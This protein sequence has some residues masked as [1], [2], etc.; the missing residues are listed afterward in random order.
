MQMKDMKNKF[1]IREKTLYSILWGCTVV[2]AGAVIVLTIFAVSRRSDK[3][4]A[5]PVSSVVTTANAGTSAPSTSNRV[6]S[7]TAPDT[8]EEINAPVLRFVLP[9]AGSLAKP[10]CIDTLSYSITMND[11]RTHRGVDLSA[12]IGDAVYACADGMITGVYSDPLMGK[13]IE[14]THAGGYKS[15]YKNLAEELPEGVAEGCSVKAGQVIAAIGESARVELAEEPHLHF[16]LTLNGNP[17]D[18]AAVLELE[19]KKQES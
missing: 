9:A 1:P 11:Y 12:E 10:H 17:V 5:A 2:A 14:I 19:E 6:P 15:L 13:C 3:V 18:P 16:E 7:T 8:S 4:P